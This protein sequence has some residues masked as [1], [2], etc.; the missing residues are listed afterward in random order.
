MNLIGLYAFEQR[1]MFEVLLV[2][3]GAGLL[4]TWIVLRGLAFYTHAV[5][6][7]AFPGLVLAAGLGFAPMA[8]AMGTGALVAAGVGGVSAR[9]RAHYDV[10]TALTLVGAL[11]VGVVLASNVFHSGS[12]VDSLLFGSL[13]ALTDLDLA[14]G[15]VASALALLATVV[16]GP[17]WLATGFD[18]AGARALGARSRLPDLTLLALVAFA[19]VATLAA[20]GALLATALLVVPAATARL[21]TSR[22]FSWQLASVALTAAVGLG[23]VWL[24]VRTNAPPGATVAALGGGV[25]LVSAVANEIQSRYRGPNA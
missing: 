2:S 11:V 20:V 21:W 23:G 4:G 9:R 12:E 6:A 25:F 24:S 14:L 10:A 13:F 16:L 17:R 5:A 7:A 15:A 22:L 18:A 8:G 1:A 3:A 19:S